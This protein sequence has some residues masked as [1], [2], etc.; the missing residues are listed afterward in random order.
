M[1][2][3]QTVTRKGKGTLYTGFQWRGRASA[4]GPAAPGCCP[5]AAAAAAASEEVWREVMFVERTR[6]EM[7]GRWFT[8]S[9]D[10]TG[11]DVK[12]VKVTSEP[13]VI[14]LS[15]AALKTSSTGLTVTILGA[16]LPSGLTAA[17][18]SLGQGIKVSKIGSISA[19]AATITVDVAADARPGPRDISVAG[20]VK[21]AAVTVF[22]KSTA[23]RSCRA[24]AWRG[25]AARCSRSSCSSSRRLRSTT[26]PT[27]SRTRKTT[28]RSA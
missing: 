11:L 6:K 3:G 21:P 28:R 14:G 12:L 7:W 25:S 9:Y 2:G 26:A 24:P 5:P 8:G 15:T 18:V 16:N 27:A 10:E 22:D 13:V 4:N 20:A 17:D 23:S 19:D 1:K